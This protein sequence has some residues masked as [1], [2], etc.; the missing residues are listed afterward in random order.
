MLFSMYLERLI[1]ARLQYTIKEKASKEMLW[2]QI[3]G[4]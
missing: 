2:D 4:Q 1:M 3:E